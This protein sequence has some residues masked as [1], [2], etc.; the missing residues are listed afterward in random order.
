MKKIILTTDSCADLS[1]EILENKNIYA[2]PFSINFPD[3]TVYDG[4][5]P[6]KEIYDFHE[7]TKQIPKTNAVSTFEYKEFF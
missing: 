2:V 5:I 3:R 6:I 1:N 4:E 7:K